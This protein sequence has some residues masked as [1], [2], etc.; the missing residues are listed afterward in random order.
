MTS[1]VTATSMPGYLLLTRPTSASPGL[2]VLPHQTDKC[3]DLSSGDVFFQEFSVIVK[4]GGDGV[5]SQHII[6]NLLLH[7]AK[8]LGYILL[9]RKKREVSRDNERY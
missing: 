7:E 3:V 6:A 5:F 4:Q 1:S 8:L 9:L 2:P